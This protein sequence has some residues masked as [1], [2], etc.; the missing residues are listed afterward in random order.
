M[1]KTLENCKIIRNHYR[2]AYTNGIC[3]GVRVDGVLLKTCITCCLH[4][5]NNARKICKKCGKEFTSPSAVAKFCSKE[6]RIVYTNQKS[7]NKK[8]PK[9]QTLDE[10]L[11]ELNEYNRTHGTHLT[12]GKYQAMKFAEALKNEKIRI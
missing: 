7:K 10:V 3:E 4:D 5:V 1:L 9:K 2:P 11:A 12:Y 6:C 8:T